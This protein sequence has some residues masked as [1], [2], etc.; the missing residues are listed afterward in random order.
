MSLRGVVYPVVRL[1]S[2]SPH[3][4]RLPGESLLLLPTPR[5]SECLPTWFRAPVLPS[6]GGSSGR[7]PTIAPQVTQEG[8]GDAGGDRWFFTTC[9]TSSCEGREEKLS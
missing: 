2:R 6:R 9:Q 3:Q 4:T 1:L 8:L 7:V 5:L